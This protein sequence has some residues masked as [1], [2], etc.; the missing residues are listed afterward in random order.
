MNCGSRDAA[1][2]TNLLDEL[3]T[4]LQ[5]SIHDASLTQPSP[6]FRTF[7]ASAHNAPYVTQLLSNVTTGVALY[8][9]E[10]QFQQTGSPLLVCATGGGQIVGKSGGVD[11]YYQCLLDPYDSLFAISGTPY[12]VICPYLFSSGDPDL[13]PAD[14]CLTVNTSINR[15]R[16]LG[17]DFKKF[18]V[19]ILLEGIVH[20]YIYA[21]TGISV[22]FAT[23]A[24]ECARLG[25]AQT[26]ENPSNYLYYVASK[27]CP[28]P[29]HRILH[30][31][32]GDTADCSM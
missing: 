11:Y 1:R 17:S 9:P 26:V 21:T 13:P 3:W 25:A 30:W 31:L 19:W 12:I 14:N 22:D 29:S 6:A 24:N 2:L 15:F 28:F 5:L 18:K 20:Y 10:Q 27:P 32:E 16:Q 8:P 23:D 4:V 7:F